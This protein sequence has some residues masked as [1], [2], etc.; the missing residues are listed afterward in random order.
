MEARLKESPALAGRRGRGKPRPYESN[1]KTQQQ[2][3]RFLT[4]PSAGRFGMTWKNG[5]A[6]VSEQQAVPL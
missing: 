1:G 3:S 2:N 4:R 5:G 6:N